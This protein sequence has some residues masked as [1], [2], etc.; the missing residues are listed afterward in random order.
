M[1]TITGPALVLK[2]FDVDPHSGRVH[3][4]GRAPGL[5]SFFLSLIGVDATTEFTVSPQEIHMRS[6][7]FFGEISYLTPITKIASMRSGYAK[8]VQLLIAAIATIWTVILPIVFLVLYFLEKRIIVQVETTGS[9]VYGI[10]FKRSLI[11]NVPVDVDKAKA[12]VAIINRNMMI[13]NGENPPPLQMPAT[14]G[15]LPQQAGMAHPQTQGYGQP[16]QPQ[17]PQQGQQQGYQQPPQ[18]GGYGGQPPQ[19]GGFGQ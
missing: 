16:Q 18:Q 5:I 11:E 2:R 19:G 14:A 9:T 3:I 4:V 8:P 12:V 7:S 10:A 17:Q 6:A 1:I 15:A 13:A